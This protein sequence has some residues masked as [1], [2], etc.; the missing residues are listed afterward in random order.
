MGR[1]FVTFG[2]LIPSFYP[3]GPIGAAILGWALSHAF[4][5]RMEVLTE[6]KIVATPRPQ[7]P[8]NSHRII[9]PIPIPLD[10]A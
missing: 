8:G 10:T 4:D 6:A 5:A 3:Y 9:V 1:F 2:R 7:H